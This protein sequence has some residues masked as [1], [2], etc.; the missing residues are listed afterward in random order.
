M[1]HNGVS[2]KTERNDVDGVR[3]LLKWLSYVPKHKGA[4]LPITLSGDP[5]ERRVDYLPPDS[6]SYDPRY[7]LM[8]C[9]C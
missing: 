7:Y 8:E 1:Y 5:V 6:Q 4:P 9:L 2:H 3:R